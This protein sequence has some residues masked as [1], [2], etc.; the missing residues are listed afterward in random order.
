MDALWQ[1]ALEKLRERLG[2]QNF[3]TWIM[4]IRFC[5]QNGNEIRLDV[6]NKFFRDWLMDHFIGPIEQVLGSLERR[7][8]K[9]SL[10][11]NQGLQNKDEPAKNEKKV[12]REWD[13]P[14]RPSNHLIAK[15]TFENFVIGASNQF[16][17]A[18]SIAVA[19]QPGDHYNPLFIY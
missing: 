19:N 13:K 11:V 14:P 17:H 7:D 8:V 15:Y 1:G 10:T 12:D 6:P 2:K 5:E 9:V 4:P 16:A 18:A 3:E